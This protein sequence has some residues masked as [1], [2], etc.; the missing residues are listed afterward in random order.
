MFAIGCIQAQTCHTGKCPTGVTSQDP[1]R[2]KALDVNDKYLR[3]SQ[4]HGNTMDALKHTTEACGL[5]HPDQFTAHH[6]M[7]RINS[8]EVRSA[9]SQYE[10]VGLNEILDASIE[11]PAFTKFWHMART[12]SFAAVNT[13]TEH[14]HYLNR[15]AA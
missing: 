4:F 15:S 14:P 12:D 6:L 3:V 10:W 2:Y 5:T 11:H 8:R 13:D 9:A 7:I 1:K